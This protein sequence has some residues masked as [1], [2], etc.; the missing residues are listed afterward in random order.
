MLQGHHLKCRVPYSQ[1]PYLFYLSIA[2]KLTLSWKIRIQPM[3]TVGTINYWRYRYWHG[4]N[5]SR[6]FT[7]RHLSCQSFRI[8]SCIS[9]LENL[10]IQRDQLHSDVFKLRQC[11]PVW[12]IEP[13]FGQIFGSSMGKNPS[14]KDST[15]YQVWSKIDKIG[16]KKLIL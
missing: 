16:I 7:L 9:Q 2:M 6:W 11:L 1:V 8:K 10:A 12:L 15:K 3:M 14:V 4:L 5:N 13:T